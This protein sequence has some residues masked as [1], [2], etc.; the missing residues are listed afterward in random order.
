MQS[1]LDALD[2]DD[3]CVCGVIDTLTLGKCISVM[4]SLLLNNTC[5]VGTSEGF[6]M[7]V[8]CLATL[9]KAICAH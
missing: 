8:M 6:S 9:V 2:K 4:A 7:C 5:A 3:V 1:L